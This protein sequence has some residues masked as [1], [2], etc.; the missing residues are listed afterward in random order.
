MQ[1]L[2]TGNTTFAVCLDQDEKKILQTVTRCGLGQIL[3]HSLTHIHIV[4]LGCMF[5][6]LF[7]YLLSLS[8]R[9]RC[10]VSVC[11]KPDSSA[12]WRLNQ[13]QTSA[14]IQPLHPTFCSLLCLPI[15]TFSGA[16]LWDCCTVD[17]WARTAKPCTRRFCY[18]RLEAHGKHKKSHEHEGWGLRTVRLNPELAAALVSITQKKEGSQRGWMKLK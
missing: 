5:I 16:L 18:L 10:E 17:L 1:V 11:Y 15:V 7:I 3:R 14:Q 2:G 6:Y 4:Y 12:D 8:A 9:Y 13:F